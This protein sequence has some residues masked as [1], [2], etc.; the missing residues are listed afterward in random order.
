[1][2]YYRSTKSSFFDP[3]KS[4]R[5]VSETEA[6]IEAKQR[7]YIKICEKKAKLD[8]KAK[9]RAKA[10]LALGSSIVIGQ[11]GFIMAGTFLY[12]SW[13]IMEPI[14]YVMMLGNFTFGMLFYAKYKE[15]FELSTLQEMISK[16]FAKGMYRR[17]GIDIVKLEDLEKEIRENQEILSKS[18]Y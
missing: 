16:S 3:T 12:L 4:D 2:A 15:E 9:R 5:S 1:M 11:F 17:N 10:L 7:E 6:I 8:K 13:D 18:I 14:S